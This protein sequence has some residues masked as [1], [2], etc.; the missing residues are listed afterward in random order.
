[1]EKIIIGSSKLKIIDVVNVARFGA[2]VELSDE[3]I[4]NINASRKVVEDI[5]NSG[6]VVY[7]MNTGYGKFENVLIDKNDLDELQLRLI[8]SDVCGVGDPLPVECVRAMMLIRINVLCK[9]FSGVRLS[10]VE[11]LVSMLNKGVTP[12]V[13]EK[14][15]VGASGDLCPLAHMVMPML[16]EGE[17]IYD[18]KVMSGKEAMAKAGIETIKLV[19][20]EGLALINGPTAMT[21][22]AALNI[23]DA[24]KLIKSADIVA[25]LT[26]EALTGIVDAFDK[27]IHE[28]RIHRGQVVSAENLRKLLNNSH[29]ATRAGE[30]RVQDAYSIRCIPQVHGAIRLAYDYAYNVVEDE[31]NAVCDNPLTFTDSGDI[32]SG[33]NFHGEAIAIAMDTLGIAMAEI[34]DISERRIARLVDPALNNGLP[35]FIIKDGGINCGYMIPHY[36]AAAL[37]SENKILAHPS[38]VD[39][40]PTSAGQEDHVSFGTIGARKARTIIEHSFHVLSIEWICAA[41][42]CEIR[43]LN[44]FENVDATKYLGDGGKIAF[45]TLRKKVPYCVKDIPFYNDMNEAY[46][47]VKSGKLLEDVENK[48]GKLN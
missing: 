18:G 1:M 3:A 44:K 24:E 14:G 19:S 31:C 29:L 34:G 46:E 45:E 42:G 37:V 12:I 2:L 5:I 23:Y 13:P 43:M 39:S 48:L 36:T 33:G 7:G 40:I 10:T 17:A 11:T 20:R 26:V 41:Q 38:S 35:A 8:Y 6:K 4:K 27:R 30:L 15:S 16:G 28:A 21:G 9:G 22:I 32:V 47:L 25:S